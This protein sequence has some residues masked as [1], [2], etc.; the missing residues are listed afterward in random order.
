MSDPKD[1]PISPET[2]WEFFPDEDV[3]EGPPPPAEDAAMHLMPVGLDPIP[4][5]EE[6]DVVV[7]YLE[8]EHPEIPDVS[9]TPIDTDTTGDVEDL[10]IRQHYLPPEGSAD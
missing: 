10:L 5:G 4:D 8:D 2:P 6:S 3:R 7:H 9:E 1:R